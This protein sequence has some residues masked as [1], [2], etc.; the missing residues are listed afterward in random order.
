GCDGLFQAP[1][2]GGEEQL[3]R[4]VEIAAE[5]HDTMLEAMAALNLGAT[6]QE[7]GAFEDSLRWSER[8]VALY[9]DGIGFGSQVARLNLAWSRLELGDQAAAFA[10]YA[11]CLRAEAALGVGFGLRIAHALEGIAACL[12]DSDPGRSARLL[13]A[14]E[15]HA[16]PPGIR[17]AD[18]YEQGRSQ[19]LASTLGARLGQAE[20]DR[21]A[22]GGAGAAIED[23]VAEALTLTPPPRS[24]V[25][26][27]P[28]ERYGLT[29]REV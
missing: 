8:A 23:V 21:L 12:A 14:A 19:T 11:D 26:P 6:Y 3:Q 7:Q 5:Q 4:A 27:A 15:H 25:T 16:P 9:G 17:P 22:A 10:Q 13:G 29:A 20:Y 1:W 18:T 28:L 24:G 2:G